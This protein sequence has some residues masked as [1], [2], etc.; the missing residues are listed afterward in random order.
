MRESVCGRVDPHRQLLRVDDRGCRQHQRSEQQY[1]MRG[2]GPRGSTHGASSRINQP[3]CECPSERN[4]GALYG[5]SRGPRFADCPTAYYTTTRI[6]RQ[7]T[8]PDS[9]ARGCRAGRHA[10]MVLAWKGMWLPGMMPAPTGGSIGDSQFSSAIVRESG[11]GCLPSNAVDDEARDP[12][13]P[14]PVAS[15]RRRSCGR[16]FGIQ[17]STAVHHAEAQPTAGTP[18]AGCIDAN[19]RAVRSF[20]DTGTELAEYDSVGAVTRLQGVL[21]RRSSPQSMQILPYAKEGDSGPPVVLALG[22]GHR[23][24]DSSRSRLDENSIISCSTGSGRNRLTSDGSAVPAGRA[25]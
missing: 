17:A 10:R 3:T 16:K 7:A 13:R 9:G 2:N 18:A 22:D 8:E 5:Y 20:G 19:R 15:V 11:L 6:R 12:T 21:D 14:M 23:I 25:S 24:G 1:Q 4:S